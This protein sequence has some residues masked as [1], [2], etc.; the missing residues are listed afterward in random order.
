MRAVSLAASAVVFVLATSACASESEPPD[1]WAEY[2]GS[3]EVE[4]DPIPS[5]GSVQDRAAQ[6]AAF[7]SPDEVAAYLMSAHSCEGAT[8]AECDLDGQYGMVSKTV[9]ESAGDGA[10]VFVRYNVVEREDGSLEVM[11]LWV[12]VESGGDTLLVDSKGETYGGL[13]DFRNHNGLLDSGDW[14][15]TARDPMDVEGVPELVTVTGHA[16]PVWIPWLIGGVGTLLALA[17]GFAVT[18]RIRRRRPRVRAEGTS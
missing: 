8:A 1:L 16:W 10:E 7:G 14:L 15:L 4:N 11:P 13:E 17:A 18:V 9:R 5:E 6:F 2:V 12:V 3:V